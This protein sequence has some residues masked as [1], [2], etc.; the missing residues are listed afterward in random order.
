MRVQP[1][2]GVA[3]LECTVV[4][5]SGT[6]TVVFLGRRD[7]AGLHVGRIVR[8]EGVVGEHHGRLAMLNPR[9]ELLADPNAHELPPTGH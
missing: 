4:A 5:D 9:L 3:T 1:R 7:I 8:V 6:M 2:A